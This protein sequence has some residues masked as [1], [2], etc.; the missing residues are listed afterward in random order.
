MGHPRL[1][2]DGEPR[3]GVG[4]VSL[5]PAGAVGLYVLNPQ[6]VYVYTYTEAGVATVRGSVGVLAPARGLSVTP[7]APHGKTGVPVR[8]PPPPQN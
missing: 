8:A 6:A 2:R 5:G 1:S 4:E 3:T 7:G